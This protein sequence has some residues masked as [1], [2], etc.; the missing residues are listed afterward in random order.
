[1]QTIIDSIKATLQPIMDQWV[2][3]QVDRIQHFKDQIAADDAKIEKKHTFNSRNITIRRNSYNPKSEYYVEGLN[4]SNSPW[5]NEWYQEV[6]SFLTLIDFDLIRQGRPA[7]I[8]KF[9][10]D[11]DHKML[12]VDF[13]VKKKLQG[14]NPRKAEVIKAAS[15]GKDGFVEGSWKITCHTGKQYV[16]SFETFYAGGHNIQ[17]F[18]VRTKYKLKEI[19]K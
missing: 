8:K 7:S 3:K 19:L 13:A 12:K 10:K 15:T 5:T 14:I 16:F 6:K 9:K 17:C 18:H 4:F 2:E 11:A 1:M